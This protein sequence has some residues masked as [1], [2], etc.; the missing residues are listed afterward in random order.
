MK[1]I[2]QSSYAVYFKWSLLLYAVTAYFSVGFHH[3]DEH[4]Q[5]LEFSTY[6]L[7]N[8]P[9]A[10]LPWE[11]LAQIR[12]ALQPFIA[13]YFTSFFHFIGLYNPFIIASVFR[14]IMAFLAWF[15]ICKLLLLFVADFA[16]ERG[17]KLFILLSFFLW[18]LPYINVRFSSENTATISFLWVIYLVLKPYTSNLKKI[19]SF[20]SIGFLIGLTFFFRFQ[21]AFAIIGLGVWLLFIKKISLQNWLSL[22]LSS[23]IIMFICVAIDRW[24]YGTWILTPYNYFSVN[25]IQ[26]VAAS[27]GV[28][29]WW[30]YFELFIVMA[31]PPLS[32]VLFWFL[33]KG[34]LF[35][36][37]HIFTFIL[38]PFLIGHF[39]IGH[40]EMRFLFPMWFMFIYLTSVGID[41]AIEKY[42]A[43]KFLNL[44]VINFSFKFFI[45][46]NGAMLIYRTF[47]PAQETLPYY[48]YGYY[49]LKPNS[50]VL[51][52]NEYLFGL[53]GLHTNF[54][55]PK[56]ITEILFNNETELS[57]YFKNLKQDSAIVFTNTANLGNELKKYKNKRIYTLYPEWILK[58]NIN[59]WEDRANISSIYIIYKN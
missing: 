4:F 37:Q 12:P 33:G 8:T 53:A 50:T 39:A 43:S 59:N 54:Y 28:D 11:F 7:Q 30:K 17:K 24:F 55:K 34:V 6:K 32:L 52:I 31:V 41:K 19:V 26:N 56:T 40:K 48:K 13:Y 44:K 36:P 23:S 35:K 2:F 58:F 22:I 1:T 29:P 27:F 15:I 25:I 49:N 16:T 51:C 10:D 5:I 20:F 45:I 42:Q 47:A 21:M 3:P 9:P 38:I 14:L 46:L 57:T 18:F